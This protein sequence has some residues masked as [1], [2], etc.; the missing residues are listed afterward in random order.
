LQG[1]CKSLKSKGRINV[2]YHQV[3]DA[4]KSFATALFVCTGFDISV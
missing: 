3:S 2:N 1:I 4:A